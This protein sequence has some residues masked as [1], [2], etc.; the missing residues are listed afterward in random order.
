MGW[1]N[2]GC[3]GLQVTVREVTDQVGGS[4]PST[5]PQAATVVCLSKALNLL[6]SRG[7]VSWL[8]LCYGPNFKANWDLQTNKGFFF[9]DVTCGKQGFR[10]LRQTGPHDKSCVRSRSLEFIPAQRE[11]EWGNMKITAHG[12]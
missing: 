3:S 8:T 4:G 6:C 12:N 5:K 7:T 1:L 2:R 10:H 11:H 9:L